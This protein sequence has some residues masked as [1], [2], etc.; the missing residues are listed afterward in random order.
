MLS[1]LKGIDLHD[2]I[3]ASASPRR[4]ELLNLLDLTFKVIPSHVEEVYSDHLTPLEYVLENA[5]KKGRYIAQKYPDSLV[6]SA[7]T[8]VV[9]KDQILEKPR[10]ERH[11][12]EILTRLSGHTHQV[13]TAFGLIVE[14]KN[15]EVFDYESTLVT[16]R[17]LSQDEIFAYLETGE[18]FDKAGGYGAQKYGAVL[19]EK[20]NGCFFNVIGLP[21]SK[22]FTTLNKFLLDL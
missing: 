11:A 10:D 17:N 21:L 2:V 13:L 18:P 14:N 1:L 19:I 16:F 5:R 7:D 9:F 20:V 12:R 4:F 8:I 15:R 6:I 3:L 22:F